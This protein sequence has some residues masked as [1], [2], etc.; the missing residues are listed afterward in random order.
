MNATEYANQIWDMIGEDMLEGRVPDTLVAFSQLHTYVDANE[1]TLQADVPYDLEAD[2]G[3]DLVHEVEAEITRRL[4]ERYA[5][6][7]AAEPQVVGAVVLGSCKD[8]DF[9]VFARMGEGGDEDW[10]VAGDVGTAKYATVLEYTTRE[11]EV[12]LPVGRHS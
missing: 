11:R 8:G 5:T 1:Y 10:Q 6:L 12:L 4:A 3:M 2:G 7:L 9:Y